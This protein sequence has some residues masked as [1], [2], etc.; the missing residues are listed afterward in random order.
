MEGKNKNLEPYLVLYGRENSV[1]PCKTG[2][3]VAHP[4]DY[5]ILILWQLFYNSVNL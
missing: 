3:S 1:L 4:L 5:V 2:F